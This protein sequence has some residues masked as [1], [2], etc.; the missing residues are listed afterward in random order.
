VHRSPPRPWTGQWCGGR[1]RPADRRCQGA[2][3]AGP[4]GG[5]GRGRGHARGRRERERGEREA[6]H[7]GRT[8]K[9]YGQQWREAHRRRW[10]SS[11]PKRKSLINGEPKDGS[12]NQKHR[13]EVLDDTNVAVLSD[14][15]NNAWIKSNC[16]LELSP[17][18]EPSQTSASIPRIVDQNWGKRFRGLEGARREG[19]SHIYILLGFEDILFLVI[20]PFLKLKYF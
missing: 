4:R 3:A 11:E 18:L 13:D 5:W 17:Q 10:S 16:S 20:I 9:F 14:S 8:E 2:A 19:S 1:R 15:A 12:M 6:A 7:L